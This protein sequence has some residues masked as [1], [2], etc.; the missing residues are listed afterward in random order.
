[1]SSSG[2][3]RAGVQRGAV[4]RP[5]ALAAER[6]CS[7]PSCPAP[8]SA[9]LTFNYAEREA[10]ITDL[11]ASRLPQSYD[12]CAPH[13]E[14]TQPP[15]GWDLRDRRED[16]DGSSSGAGAGALGG[17]DTV[18]VLAAALRAVPDLPVADVSSSGRT[19]DVD[20]AE[21]S[22][23]PVLGASTTSQEDSTTSQE[24]STTS[25]EDSTTSRTGSTA[26]PTPAPATRAGSTALP[27]QA[28]APREDADGGA[29]SA[30]RP[31]PVL[32][33][34]RRTAPSGDPATDW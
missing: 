7:R 14:R 17:P 21:G 13:A 11:A 28:P 33:A 19:G 12:L 6:A 23:S 30:A 20:A 25:Q 15:H 34:R 4:V 18:A 27:A 31:R 1:M 3:L 29:E 16:E 22:T 10:W 8:A 2:E 32:A 26:L 9:T 5:L 24:D